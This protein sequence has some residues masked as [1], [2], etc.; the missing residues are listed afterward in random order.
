MA[1]THVTCC[2]PQALWRIGTHLPRL[3]PPKSPCWSSNPRL[4]RSVPPF[5]ACADNLLSA[6]NVRPHVPVTACASQEQLVF[7][8]FAILGLVKWWLQK[9]RTQS[10]NVRPRTAIERA[11]SPATLSYSHP[12]WP[13]NLTVQLRPCTEQASSHACRAWRK[14][15]GR[16]AVGATPHG[17]ARGGQISAVL[18]LLIHTLVHVGGRAEAAVGELGGGHEGDAASHGWLDSR[19]GCWGDR[20]WPWMAAEWHLRRDADAARAQHT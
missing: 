14:S 9:K 2:Q 3:Q 15:C 17:K 18:A 5:T 13:H 16:A 6:R 7:E 8:V 12:L 10:A 1:G 19:R 4:S 11:P 20:P